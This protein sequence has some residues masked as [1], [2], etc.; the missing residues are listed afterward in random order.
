MEKKYDLL[1]KWVIVAVFFVL[2]SFFAY[3]K[4]Y[5]NRPTVIFDVTE[6]QQVTMKDHTFTPQT[7]TVPVNTTVTWVNN[8]QVMHTVTSETN[9]FSSN[10]LNPGETFSYQFKTPGVYKYHCKYYEQMIA[11]VMVK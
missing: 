5:A 10:P 7:I 11:T 8:D 3:D 9:L 6:E 2:A 1:R 4:L